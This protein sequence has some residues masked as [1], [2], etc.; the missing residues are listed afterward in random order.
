MPKMDKTGMILV[1][2]A[3]GLGL[4]LLPGYFQKRAEG[5]G[6]GEE[7]PGLVPME[8]APADMGPDVPTEEVRKEKDKKPVLV[9]SARPNLVVEANR[10]TYGTWQSIAGSRNRGVG[11]HMKAGTVDVWGATNVSVIAD[12]E[13]RNPSPETL[14]LDF[15][16]RLR[17]IRDFTTKS[18]LL[19]RGWGN[20]F[21]R[22][23]TSFEYTPEKGITNDKFFDAFQASVQ[24]THGATRG[25]RAVPLTI[26]PGGKADLRMGIHLPG[27]ARSKEL[28]EFWESN[29]QF[30]F[31][32]E[33]H[34]G[35]KKFAEH[36]F[37]GAFDTSIVRPELIALRSTR[38]GDSPRLIIKGLN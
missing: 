36:E 33:P 25:S 18:F 27:P 34:Q 5:E 9:A 35:K 8:L 10:A 22:D 15:R 3:V 32:V 24:T 11:N 28:R 21:G 30:N 37:K 14:P 29:P 23:E 7:G 26:S 20:T 6:E 16:V 2:G 38:D 13:I 1:G 12:W 31:L 19:G 4:L 17:M